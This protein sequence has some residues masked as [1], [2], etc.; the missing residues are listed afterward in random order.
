MLLD[1]LLIGHARDQID[2]TPFDG[3]VRV[4]LLWQQLWMCDVILEQ[5][6]QDLGSL[7]SGWQLVDRRI[8]RLE[9]VLPQCV[10]GHQCLGIELD[11]LSTIDWRANERLRRED[12]TLDQGVDALAMSLS[13]SLQRSFWH[14]FEA[15]DTCS[16]GIFEVVV[17][18]GD[19]VGE[20]D[21]LSLG[22][23]RAACKLAGEMIVR[24]GVLQDAV[25]RV[26]CEIEAASCLL[27]MIDDPQ[28]LLV[29]AESGEDL[30][31]RSLARMTERR[32]TE[33]VAEPDRFN[34]V[35]VQSQGAGNCPGDLGDLQSV[36]QT[37]SRLISRGHEEDL[38]LRLQSSKGSRVDDA[39]PIALIVSAKIAT[40]FNFRSASRRRPESSW[41]EPSIFLVLDLLPYGRYRLIHRVSLSFR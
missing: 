12:R 23:A 1:G 35:F 21:D 33:I 41:A 29:V 9:E 5:A 26:I 36:C 27:K 34:Q 30:S 40:L 39:V 7:S 3:V 16:N 31:K 22:A 8:D 24:L 11:D 13:E 32:V 6:D 20:L 2:N 18:V 4:D 28:A 25:S 38:R 37:R 17:D 19:C 15:N 10:S 14:I